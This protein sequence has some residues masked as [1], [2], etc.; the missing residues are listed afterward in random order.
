METYCVL[1]DLHANAAALNAVKN[2]SGKVDH[3]WF[4]GDLFDRG[5]EGP[6]TYKYFRY[7]YERF[8]E[9][10]R[11]WLAGNHDRAFAWVRDR[12]VYPEWDIYYSRL[13]S[14]LKHAS[15][16]RA[17]GVDLS[18][19]QDAALR[20]GHQNVR[21]GSFSAYLTHGFPVA[22]EQNRLVEY[23]FDHAPA[24]EAQK[25]PEFYEVTE[26]A[27]LWVVGHSHCQSGWLYRANHSSE[28]SGWSE[29]I[30][31]FGTTLHGDPRNGETTIEIDVDLAA[32]GTGSFLIINPGS[33]GN[34]RDSSNGHLVAKYIRLEA[35]SSQLKVRFCSVRY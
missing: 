24:N 33:A 14:R 20:K 22:N 5:S 27:S 35:N 12:Q 8:P 30:P 34:P 11:V 16:Q 21:V 10:N 28:E 7:W 2:D 23:D 18:Y 6:Q 17:H 32:L 3:L 25:Y 4:L 29:L 9:E 1:S 26:H 13:D 31:N 19:V 15:E